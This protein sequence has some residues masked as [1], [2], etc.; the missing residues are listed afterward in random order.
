MTTDTVVA[1]E[2][3][4]A[5]GMPGFPTARRF[6]IERWGENESPFFLLGCL[7]D[8]DLAFVVVPPW[9]FY[10]EYDFD[11]DDAVVEKLDLR[12]PEEALVVSIVTLGDEPKDSTLNLLGPIVVN[13]RSG[14]AAQVVLHDS[15]Y[16]VR[17]PITGA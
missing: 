7:D 16:E 13:R 12:T 10:P 15:G 6:E 11:L 17:A 14:A 3:T 2:I 4:F 9:P 1:A 8:P 5:A